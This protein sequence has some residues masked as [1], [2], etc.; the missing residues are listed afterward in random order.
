M[1]ATLEDVADT[2]HPHPTYSEAV[3][4][5]AEAALGRPIHF[6]YGKKVE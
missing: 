2:I 3:Q 5:A 1:G 6:F 4:E